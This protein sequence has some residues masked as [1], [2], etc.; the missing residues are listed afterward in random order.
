MYKT[1]EKLNIRNLGKQRDLSMYIG[2]SSVD[3]QTS[4]IALQESKTTHP[5]H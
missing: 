2:G 5:Q 4:K 3:R 1:K